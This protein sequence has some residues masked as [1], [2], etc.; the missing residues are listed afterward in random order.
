MSHELVRVRP[1]FQSL[2]DGVTYVDLIRPIAPYMLTATTASIFVGVA[3]TNILL[4]DVAYAARTGNATNLMHA[5]RSGFL[6]VYASETVRLEVPEKIDA[7][8][9]VRRWNPAAIQSVWHTSLEPWIW[10]M[11]PSGLPPASPGVA[12][13]YQLDPDDGQTA[14]LVEILNPEFVFSRDYRHLSSYQLVG[15]RWNPIAEACRLKSEHDLLFMGGVFATAATTAT[16]WTGV[17]ETARVVGQIDG[18]VLASIGIAAAI[19]LCLPKSRAW[20]LQHGSELLVHASDTVRT[21]GPIIF[22][23]YFAMYE[24]SVRA[25]AFLEHE[26]RGFHRPRRLRDFATAALARATGPL[27]LDEVN[28]SVVAFGYR[29]RGGTSVRYLQTVLRDHPQLFRQ[30]SSGQWWLAGSRRC[31]DLPMALHD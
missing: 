10:F 27:T 7:L 25:V 17:R 9:S 24:R 2:R 3:D 13:T 4:L 26:R 11:D 6:R 22:A 31:G 20:L 14:Q 5:L 23:H 30:L 12:T 8:A 16:M 18:R 19:A 21:V 28:A 29:A 15:D 1:A